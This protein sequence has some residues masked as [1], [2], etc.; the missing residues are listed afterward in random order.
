MSNFNSL[1]VEQMERRYRATFINS[2]LGFKYVTLVGTINEA[3]VTNLALFNSVFHL[4]ANPPLLGMVVR[5]VRP[6]ND[7]FNNIKATGQY[8]LNNVLPYFYKQ[9]HQASAAY[10]SGVSEFEAC[11]LTPHYEEDFKPPFVA[12]A[13]IKLAMQLREIMPMQVNGT[14][15]VIGEIM[16]IIMDDALI[17]ADGYV[18]QMEAGTI[19]VSGLDSYFTAQP[20]GRLP[21]AKP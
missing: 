10:P 18:D 5:P 17:A 19:S 20:L 2:L 11:G 14:T 21:Y 16:N 8:T 1:A 6:E 7:T 3:G 12:E 15:I 4:G 13:T 9:A